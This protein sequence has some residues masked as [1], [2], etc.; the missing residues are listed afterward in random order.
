MMGLHEHGIHTE[1]SHI[2]AHVGVISK[3][4]YVFKTECAKKAVSSLKLEQRIAYQPGYS[5]P[6]ARGWLA[7][8][9]AIEDMRV[10]NCTGW[11][12]FEGFNDTLSTA[13]KGAKAV[14]IVLALIER[15]RFPFWIKAAE[16]KDKAIQISGTDIV[17]DN[18]TAIQVKCDFKAG[19]KVINGCTG[20]LFLQSHEINPLGLF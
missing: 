17:V 14:D 10:I 18:K 7:P 15:G 11:P 3:R 2:R 12:L 1:N 9:D 16:T 20:N 8:L 4:V 19:P 5:K 13:Q 6:T